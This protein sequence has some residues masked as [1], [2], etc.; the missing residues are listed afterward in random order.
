M[1]VEL[2]SL[3]EPGLLKCGKIKIKGNT[4]RYQHLDKLKPNS[5]NNLL[6]FLML[7]HSVWKYGPSGPTPTTNFLFF[8]AEEFCLEVRAIRSGKSAARTEPQK[9]QKTLEDNLAN[10]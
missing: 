8:A 2:Y 10:G 3:P 7:K 5:N 6:L 4:T 9:K 1:K